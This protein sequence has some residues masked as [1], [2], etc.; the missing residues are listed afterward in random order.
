MSD[1]VGCAPWSFAVRL[2]P[3]KFP[4][5]RDELIKNLGAAGIECRPGFYALSAQPLYNTPILGNSET[6]AEE[7]IALPAPPDLSAEDLDYIHD[8]FMSILNGD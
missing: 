4:P 2:D 5:G 8:S 1:E 6:I 7:T 3:G